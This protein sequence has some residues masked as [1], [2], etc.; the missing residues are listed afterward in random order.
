MAPSSP[1]TIA[2]DLDEAGLQAIGAR[3]ASVLRA[4]DLIFLSGELGAGKTTLARAILEGLGHRG[5][6]PSPTFMLA[7]PYPDLPLPILHADLYRLS[8]EAGIEDLGFD[9]WL[10]SGA[11]LVEWPERLPASWFPEALRLRLEG[12]GGPSRRLTWTLPAAWKGRW[13]EL[14]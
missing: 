9:Q 6:V 7:E 14:G 11:V 10:E 5:E 4:G 12:A 8:P 3:L 1:I 2:T 13:P